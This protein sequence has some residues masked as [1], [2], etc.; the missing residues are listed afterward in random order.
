MDLQGARRDA[1]EMGLDG[2]QEVIQEGLKNGVP[3]NWRWYTHKP[4][5]LESLLLGHAKFG[6]RIPPETLLRSAYVASR[7]IGRISG[8]GR[9]SSYYTVFVLRAPDGT[10]Y[11]IQSGFLGR[12]WEADPKSIEGD[13]ELYLRTR[14]ASGYRY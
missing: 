11:D 8:N 10:L 12:G 14:R 5:V 7:T 9:R 4:A 13:R 1:E 3:E 6:G 2:N